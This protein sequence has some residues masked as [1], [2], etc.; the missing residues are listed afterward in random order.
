[1]TAR[2][3]MVAAAL[4]AVA[5]LCGCAGYRWTSDVP[6]SMRTVAVPTFDNRTMSAELGPIISQY[7]LREFQR[8]GT[9]S[10]RRTGDAALEV[11]GTVEKATR[12][13]IDYDR[14]YGMR[15]KEYRYEVTVSVALVDKSSGK[16]LFEDRRYSGET[17]FL[18]QNDLLTGQRDAAQRVA[19]EIARQIVD[20]VV[21]FQYSGSGNG[22]GAV[23]GVQR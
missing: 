1:M 7:A 3:A 6:E 19:H 13:A 12:A 15:A 8:E 17:T 20:D 16:V 21:G 22:N 23:E 5:A 9:F 14:S 18:T 11:Q 10:I 4:A 2:Q